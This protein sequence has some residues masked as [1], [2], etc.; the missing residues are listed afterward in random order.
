MA[1]DL[2]SLAGLSP[3]CSAPTGGVSTHHAAVVSMPHNAFPGHLASP[4]WPNNTLWHGLSRPHPRAP[5]NRPV[6]VPLAPAPAPSPSAGLAAWHLP[7]LSPSACSPL[8]CV[9]GPGHGAGRCGAGPRPVLG[10]P[11]L[12][13]GRVCQRQAGGRDG[14]WRRR[15]QRRRRGHQRPVGLAAGRRQRR[16]GVRRRAGQGSLAVYC[17]IPAHVVQ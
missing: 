2:H 8:R 6:P 4:W 3:E 12:G 7:S 16:R 15:G 17:T 11:G 10:L 14:A 1:A 9:A 5:W 13:L